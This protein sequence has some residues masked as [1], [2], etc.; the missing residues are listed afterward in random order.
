MSS[1]MNRVCNNENNNAASVVNNFPVSKGC[2]NQDQKSAVTRH[3]NRFVEEDRNL[4]PRGPRGPHGQ[5]SRPHRGELEGSPFPDDVV[6]GNEMYK[7]LK[8]AHPT[9][10]VGQPPSPGRGMPMDGPENGRRGHPPAPGAGNPAEHGCPEPPLGVGQVDRAPGP[11]PG[12]RNALPGDPNREHLNCPRQEPGVPMERE[13]SHPPAG[14]QGCGK[15]TDRQPGPHPAL[16]AGKPNDGERAPVKC[17]PVEH[18]ANHRERERGPGMPF[19]HERGLQ[20]RSPRDNGH[21]GA[22]VSVDSE[23]QRQREPMNCPRECRQGRGSPPRQGMP[24]SHERGPLN[25]PPYG[26]HGPGMPFER[27]RRPFDCPRDGSGMP[28]ERQP[29]PHPHAMERGQSMEGCPPT[30]HQRGEQGFPRAAAVKAR[31]GSST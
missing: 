6:R 29:G 27:E 2:G 25:G 31:A 7:G 3:C 16:G 21:H 15:P 18:Q 9:G 1:N 8:P 17:P 11:H 22:G 4:G 23:R 30:S 14:H 26:Q 12:P 5:P 20:D 24:A 13:P 28:K 19:D 10:P